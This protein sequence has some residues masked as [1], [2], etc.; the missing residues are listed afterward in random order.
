[1]AGAAGGV[2]VVAG[3]VVV[4]VTVIRAVVV[5]ATVVGFVVVGAT[6]AGATVAEVEVVGSTN[7]TVG[8]EGRVLSNDAATSTNPTTSMTIGPTRRA[9][10]T[11]LLPSPRHAVPWHSR[12]L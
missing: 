12:R 9:P 11:S 1:M 2:V 8:P 10:M 6:V 4:V 3:P 5:R 7:P